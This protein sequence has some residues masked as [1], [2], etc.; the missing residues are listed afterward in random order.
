MTYCRVT[1]QLFEVIRLLEEENKK[2]R[3]YGTGVLITHGEALF[4]ETVL[5]YPGEN[6]S[7][8]SERLGITKGA[9][10]QM[11]EKLSQKELIG[12]VQRDGNKKEKYFRPT[13]KGVLTIQGR[14]TLHRQ[15]NQKLCD[16]IAALDQ[17]EADTVFRF[18]ECLRECAPFCEFQ[19]AC[20]KA[21]RIDKEK[22]YGETIAAACER[23]ACRA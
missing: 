15:A 3:D 19:C 2:S 5:R 20:K 12:T 4:L 14:Q 7:A 16:F 18:L 9:V 13:Q 6:V 22:H 1:E 21:N 10:T 17:G 8:L 23:A 11:V